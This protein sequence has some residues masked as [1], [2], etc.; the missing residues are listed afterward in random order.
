MVRSAQPDWMSPML[1]TLTD[2]RFSDPGWLFERKFDGERCLAFRAEDEIRLMSRNRLVL[3]SHYPEI[4]D[5]LARQ[6]HRRFVVDGEVVAF[7]GSRDSFAKLQRRMQLADPERSRRSGVAVFYYVFDVLHFDEFDLT[8]LRLRDRKAVLRKAISFGGPLRSTAHR[9]NDGDLYWR[10]AC[11]KGWEGVIAK[12]ADSPYVPGRSRQWLKF[13]CGNEQEFVIGGYTDPQGSRI[14]FGA[15]LIGY[16]EGEDLV[17]AGKV[18]TG[19]DR[20][21]LTS[22]RS[23]L[24]SLEQA[25]PP[26]AVGRLPRKGVH[27]VR[28]VLVCQVG[29]TEWTRDG[30]LRHPRFLGLR[31]DKS[32]REVAR[33]MPAG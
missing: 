31:R 7:E 25:E 14:G 16:Y 29:F 20:E 15:L 11:R 10:D 3:N 19:F 18:G 5:A 9:K 17:F 22:L 30:Q 12:N 8:G 2:R 33:E 21:L 32:P 13:K 4:V 24:S 1:A 23:T 27:W 26:F 28:P 6:P